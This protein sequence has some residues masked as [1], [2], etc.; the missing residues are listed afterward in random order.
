MNE[1]ILALL[2]NE[3]ETHA[4]CI[5]IYI[6]TYICRTVLIQSA[7]ESPM[8]ELS[9]ARFSN[10]FGAFLTSQGNFEVVRLVKT[11]RNFYLSPGFIHVTF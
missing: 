5:F 11:R 3:D 7:L 10:T 2:I 8:F 1:V 6:V 4:T 9:N